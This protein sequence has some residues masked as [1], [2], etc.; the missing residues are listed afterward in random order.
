MAWPRWRPVADALIAPM[1]A[2]LNQASDTGASQAGDGPF[3]CAGV[4]DAG[5]FG[6]GIGAMRVDVM[7]LNVIGSRT[8]D[9]CFSGLGSRN[10]GRRPWR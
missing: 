8:W 3:R 1:G 9:D 5:R 7:C 6:R 10:G 2:D 4:R